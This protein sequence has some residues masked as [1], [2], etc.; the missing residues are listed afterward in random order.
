MDI[1][2]LIDQLESRLMEAR[3]VPLTSNVLINE[4]EFFNIID[5]MRSRVPE[6][7]RQAK[8]TL[9]E[10]DR[11]IAQAHEEAERIVALAREKADEVLAEHDTVK[12]AEARAETI[13]ERAQREADRIKV[14]AD[15]YVIT[16]L[17]QLESQLS[18]LLTT[19]RNGIRV[20]QEGRAGAKGRK[21]GE[22]A[23]E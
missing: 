13:I 10:R 1:L 18:S 3:R 8:K 9:R 12:M 16:V 19:V 22:E 6:E 11:I 5:E 14:D 15:D 23:E 21:V 2:Y 4:E 17:S 7:V 20:V